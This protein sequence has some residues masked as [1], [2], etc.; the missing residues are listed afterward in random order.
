ME[1]TM[2]DNYGTENR[3]YQDE[4]RTNRPDNSKLNNYTN[5]LDED[6][7][8]ENDPES[9]YNN[10]K[11]SDPQKSNYTEEAELSNED[12]E[13]AEEFN[14]FEDIEFDATRPDFQENERDGVLELDDELDEEDEDED[15]EDEDEDDE[16][17]VNNLNYFD[18][19]SPL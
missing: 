8:D 2:N 7:F 12:A 10:D 16:D 9:F 1:N 4:N 3:N 14:D 18:P 15:Y 5:Q 17:K 19:N 11:N 13:H 6:N